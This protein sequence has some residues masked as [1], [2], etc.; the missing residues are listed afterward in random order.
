VPFVLPPLLFG[1]L[2][3]MVDELQPISRAN[4]TND[5]SPVPEINEARRVDMARTPFPEAIQNPLASRRL[6]I[7]GT[8]KNSSWP[9]VFIAI[10]AV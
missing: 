10:L 6:L 1:G 9:L 5:S 4:N 2:A 8:V 7:S 3:F